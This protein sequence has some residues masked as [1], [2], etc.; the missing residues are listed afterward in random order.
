MFASTEV[1][2]RFR[3]IRKMKGLS[4]DEVAEIL[5]VAVLMATRHQFR[6]EIGVE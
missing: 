2:Q 4:Q 1:G 6:R 3:E 5:C